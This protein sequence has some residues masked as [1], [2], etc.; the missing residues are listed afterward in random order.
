V[1]DGILAEHGAPR[2]YGHGEVLVRQGEETSTLWLIRAG[3]VRLS[4]VTASGREVVVAL[5]GPGDLFGESALLPDQRSSVEARAVGSVEIVALP[6]AAISDIVRHAPR[7]A[8]QLLRLIATRLHRTGSALEDTLAHDVPTRVSL[9]LRELAR[10]HGSTTAAGVRLPPRLTQ[11]ELAR[12]VGAT[13]ESVNRSLAVLAAR[14]LLRI[15]G[16]R[17][18]LPDPDAL[19]AVATPS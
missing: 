9:R 13:R 7:T 16:R 11:E 5:L 2:R 15:E 3:A 17:Y 6:E 19:S 8:E 10:A 14:G 4:A 12:M 1:D 18:V